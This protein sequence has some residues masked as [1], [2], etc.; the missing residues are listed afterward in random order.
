MHCVNDVRCKRQSQLPGEIFVLGP[1]LWGSVGLWHR[2]TPRSSREREHSSSR[3]GESPENVTMRSR[4]LAACV[5]AFSGSE[6]LTPAGTRRG[7]TR[8]VREGI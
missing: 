4:P 6:E 8:F 7:F 3:R 1:A 5:G 2:E